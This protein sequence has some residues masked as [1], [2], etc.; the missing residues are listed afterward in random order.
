MIRFA[1][2]LW[3]KLCLKKRYE[4]HCSEKG[5]GVR[6]SDRKVLHVRIPVYTGDVS[7][8]ASALYE[9]GGMLVIHDHLGCNSTYNTHDE[10]RWYDKEP[11]IYIGT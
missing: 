6:E 8:F 11:D 2:A 4:G 3:K 10:V 5:I 9:L 1:R 7:G